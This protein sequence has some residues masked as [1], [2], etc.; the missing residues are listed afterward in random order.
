MKRNKVQA[1]NLWSPAKLEGE[2]NSANVPTAPKRLF[3]NLCVGVRSALS[4]A[5]I[6]CALFGPLLASGSARSEDA[7]PVLIPYLPAAFRELDGPAG[8]QKAYVPK[9]VFLDLMNRAYPKGDPAERDPAAPAGVLLP[10]RPLDRPKPPPVP[11]ALGNARYEVIVVESG[12]TYRVKGSLDAQTFDPKEWTKLNLD[13]GSAQLTSVTLGGQPARVAYA[14]GVPF[15][16]LQGEGTHKLEVELHGP[17]VLSPG[18]AEFSTR[19]VGG[20]ATRV[21]VLLPADV[22]LDLK[23]LPA[24]AWVEKLPDGKTQRCSIDLGA[25]G[26]VC[27]RWYSPK[28]ASKL[29]SQI[30]TRSYSQLRLGPD[31]YDVYRVEQV[32]VEGPGVARLEFRLLGAWEIATVTAGDLAE[33]GV[34]GEGEARRLKLA[35]HKPVQ[36]AQLEITGWAPLGETEAPVAGLALDGALRHEGFIGLAHD[37]ARRFAAASLKDLKRSSEGELS[38]LVKLP[39]ERMPDRIFRFHEP[40]AGHRVSAEPVEGHVSIE[41]QSVG[42]V[43]PG[44]LLIGVRS[45]Y[46]AR[47]RTPLRHEVVL[48]AGWTVR[49]VRSKAMRAWTIEE[50]DGKRRLTVHFNARIANGAEVIWSAEQILEQPAAG[51]FT[52]PLEQPRASGDAKVHETLDWVLAADRSLTLA[53]GAATTM[54]TTPLDRA[55]A[56]VQLEP[57]EDYRFAFRS[58]KAESRLAVEV[59]P[60]ESLGACTVVSF[61]R[62]AEDHI[63]VNARCRFRIEQAGIERLVLRL[64]VGAR[65]VDLQARNLRSHEVLDRPAGPRITAILQSPVSGEQTIDLAYRLSRDPGKD[66]VVRPLEIEDRRIQRVEHFVGLLQLER[67]LV[68]I[69]EQKGLK[70]LDDTERLPYL[71]ID[72]SGGALSQAFAAEPQWSLTLRQP[73]V[74]AEA[75]Q[76][77]EIARA[78]LKTVVAGDGRVRS[79]ATYTVHNRSRQFL[80]IVLPEQATLWGVLVDGRPVT[81][82]KIQQAQG[83]VLLVPIQR[84]GITDLALE[85]AVVYEDARIELPAGLRT[86][87]PRAPKVLGT[88]VVETFWQLYVPEDYQVTRSGGNVSDVANTVLLAGKLKGNVKDVERLLS[89]V[90]AA[91]SDQRS[92]RQALRSLSRLQQDLSDNWAEM[93]RSGPSPSAE[94]ARRI[95]QA[96]LQEQVMGNMMHQQKASQVHEQL[97][98]RG[99]QIEEAIA[100]K[101]VG[102]EQQ[103][104]RDA[105]GFMGNKWR[106][107]QKYAEPSAQAAPPAK[108]EVPLAALLNLRRF[109]GFKPGEVPALPGLAPECRDQ[110]LAAETGLKGDSA[111][112]L[113]GEI[114]AAEWQLPVEGNL[115]TFRR[116]EGH[117]ELALTLRSSAASWL[118]AS[119]ILLVLLLAVGVYIFRR[120]AKRNAA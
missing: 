107:G 4:R 99:K 52:L 85:V 77:A 27:M 79:S 41:T 14:G 74:A 104:F 89:V 22:E 12:Q 84:V 24:G 81:V 87:A 38:T 6:A 68:S 51:T 96:D 13:F 109:S 2:H 80:Q 108:G 17:L 72:V 64:P 58:S 113:A 91:D 62:A 82:S 70:K 3:K 42:V 117:P 60:R 30:A 19:L 11:L 33:W 102:T 111:G 92:K 103:N 59:S 118:T 45:R 115:Y 21:E 15:I 75:G 8:Q 78:I 46:T 53:Q 119:R 73:E 110:P 67:G 16:P 90:D 100:G 95:G 5:V 34:S 1:T 86:L 36:G 88:D 25:G 120:R 101:G 57:S 71:P 49:T 35:F 7:G 29:A 93:E 39:P 20:A 50:A 18:R 23:P 28:I 98:G 43:R 47:G 114:S 56:W 26:D 48:P 76:D 66:A 61:L 65:L 37:P 54:Q 105:V 112:A 44:R 9:S 10:V 55:P 97:K 116:V 32:T 31:G 40:P 94:E 63:Q 106:A 69:A 83:E